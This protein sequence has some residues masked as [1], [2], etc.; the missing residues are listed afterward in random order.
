MQRVQTGSKQLIREINQALVL[1]LVRSSTRVSRVEIAKVTGLSPATVSGITARLIEHGLLRESATGESVGGR[2]PVLL[3]LVATAGYCVG[4]KVTETEVIAVLTD[5]AASVVARDRRSLLLSDPEAVVEVIASSVED[6]LPAAKGKPVHGIGVGLAGVI[7]SHNGVVHH[8][9]YSDWRDVPLGRLLEDRLDLPVTV[10]ND[11]NALVA[12]EQWFGAGRD[13]SHF[14]VISIGRGVGLGM[15]L[16]GELYRGAKGGAGEFGHVKIAFPGEQCDCGSSGCLESEVSDQAIARIVS[17]GVGREINV[18][19]AAGLARDGNQVALEAFEDAAEVLGVAT[20]NLV[21]VLDPELIVISGEGTRAADLVRDP[22]ERSLRAHCF[23]ALRDDFKVVIE[24][25]DEEAWA[26]GAASL[27][28][29]ELF[30]HSRRPEG[31]RSPSL[32]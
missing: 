25:W 10:D 4:V 19:E 26:R 17:K 3:E 11:V 32:T 22:F 24:E 5:L 6:L 16:N 9:T 29:G 27:L 18:G 23:A 8:A 13:I 21:N 15:V 20:A 31:V 2:K 28:L 30:G 1:G 14:L 12:I 7:D